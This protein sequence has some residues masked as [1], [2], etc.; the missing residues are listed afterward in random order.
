MRRLALALL[1]VVFA[2]QPVR[3]QPTTITVGAERPATVVLPDDSA[4]LHPLLLVLHGYSSSGPQIDAYTGL[5]NEAAKRGVV[6]AFPNGTQEASGFRFWN[7]TDACCN[8]H[9]S[10]VDDVSYLL[11]LIE[12]IG[13]EI[14]IDRRRVYVFGHS[15]GAF[16]A[17]RL[18]CSSAKTFAAIA[19]L[20]GGTYADPNQCA[21][22]ARL[23]VLHM[24]GTSDEVIPINGTFL[25]AEVPA[26]LRS[27][28][29]WAAYNNCNPKSLQRTGALDIESKLP[30]KETVAYGFRCPKGVDVDF[31]KIVG[32]KHSPSPN[33]NFG[34]RLF[35]WLLR[36]HR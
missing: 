5:R 22:N 33:A 12:E 13:S 21:P 29:T 10:T 35:T 14:P 1:L 4:S 36:H 18:G 7:A 26:A 20:A 17:Y 32:A 27:V 24:H 11:A 34:G 8:L 2:T 16:M 25:L 23:S 15:N 19:G 31:W 9:G 30:G 28:R 3:A 6:L